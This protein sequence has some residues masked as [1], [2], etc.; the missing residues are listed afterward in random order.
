MAICF[1]PYII[2]IKGCLLL[3]FLLSFSWRVDMEACDHSGDGV[4]LPNAQQKNSIVWRMLRRIRINKFNS[5]PLSFRTHPDLGGSGTRNRTRKHTKLDIGQVGGWYNTT[6]WWPPKTHQ[7]IVTPAPVRSQG[8]REGQRD[9][10]CSLPESATVAHWRAPCW[11]VLRGMAANP[12]VAGSALADI[13]IHIH[14]D[15][16]HRLVE[17]E[18]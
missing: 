16:G 6:V 3:S 13:H 9:G 17:L 18:I 5:F 4:Q 8:I 14:I 2:T 15:I 7:N 11:E 1:Y 12:L 10:D